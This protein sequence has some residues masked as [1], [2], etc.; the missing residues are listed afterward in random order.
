ML[1][2][3][4]PT[5]RDRAKRDAPVRHRDYPRSLTASGAQRA[6]RYEPDDNPDAYDG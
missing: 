3:T 2:N 6:P 4:R 1:A 5:N